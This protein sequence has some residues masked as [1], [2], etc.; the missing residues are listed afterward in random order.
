M[1]TW[2]E[3]RPDLPESAAM[4]ELRARLQAERRLSEQQRRE[5]IRL[6]MRLDALGLLEVKYLE[7]LRKYEE[8]TAEIK[9]RA[10]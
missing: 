1:D 4:D 10:G 6:K 8:L 5:L 3:G 9:T 7:L 2:A